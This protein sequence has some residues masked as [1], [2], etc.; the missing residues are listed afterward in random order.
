MTTQELMALL[1]LGFMGSFTPGPNTA[2]STTL[3]A[4]HG[5]R[6]ALPFVCAVPCGWGLLL[7]AS[8]AGLG[9]LVQEYPPVR[10]LLVAGGA[11]YLLWLAGRLIRTTV[12]SAQ[13][14]D[15]VPMR[16]MQGLALQFL[17]PKAWLLA[18]SVASGWVLGFDNAAMRLLEVL[19]IFM[20]FGLASNL[21]Y[22]VIG[23]ALREW[24]Q[25]PHHSGRRLVQFNRAMALGLVATAV[26]MVRD[27]WS[28]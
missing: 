1:A 16:F 5:L 21:T 25:G 3:A 22:A 24:L 2:L 15:A 8:S 28:A 26:W 10:W 27:L 13:A 23:S 4:N 6:R 9:A 7:L 14:H 18:I 19:P 11:G 20:A 17:N 12:W